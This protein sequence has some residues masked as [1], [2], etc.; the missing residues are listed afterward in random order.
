[1]EVPI[2]AAAE[3]ETAAEEAARAEAASSMAVLCCC[4]AT[5]VAPS[6]ITA[7]SSAYKGGRK[8]GVETGEN[9]R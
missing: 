6:E 4:S 5:Q 1:M 2:G 7:D 3:A 9:K 8:K